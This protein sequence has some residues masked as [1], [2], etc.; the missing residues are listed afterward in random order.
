MSHFLLELPVKRRTRIRSF[1]GWSIVVWLFV[2]GLAEGQI[3]PDN[4]QGA[5]NSQVTP[6]QNINGLPADLIEGGALRDSNLFH[7]FSE[8]NVEALRGAYFANPDGVANIFSRVTG[9]NASEIMGTLGVLGDADLFLIN[10]NGIIF[11]ENASLDV[12]GS[13]MAT[14]ADTVDFGEQGFWAADEPNQ[15]PLLTV[16]PS[17]FVFNQL[18]P[19]SIENRSVAPAGLNLSGN[20]ELAG[21]RVPDGGNLLV[22]GGDIAIDGGGLNALDGRIELAAVAGTGK[23]SL[24]QNNSLSLPDAI[25]KAN[26]SLANGAIIDT[27][28]VGRGTVIFR[29]ND[30]TMEDAGVF[31]QVIVPA[32][33][34]Q[35]D[36]DG[37]ILDAD[38][39]IFLTNS[40]LDSSTFEAGNASR[41]RLNSKES[42]TLDG[43]QIAIN[44]GDR[45]TPP[46]TMLGQ[47]GNIS[48]TTKRLWIGNESQISTLAAGTGNSG[49]INLEAESLEV[50]DASL[51]L[52]NTSGMGNAGKIEVKVGSLSL[53]DGGQ[54]LSTTEEQ[55]N[56]GQIRVMADEIALSR[57]AATELNEV[58]FGIG[59]FSSG[60]FVS[61]E[62]GASG[63]GGEIEILAD[64]LAMREGAVIGA[65]TKNQALGGDIRIDAETLTVDRGAQILTSAFDTGNAGNIE[66]NVADTLAITG[67]DPRFSA[68]REA[69]IAA[70]NRI[71]VDNP[72]QLV[73][74]VS[75]AS[76]IFANTTAGSTGNSGNITI[77]GL[78][79][80][81]QNLELSQ[82]G[83]IAVDSQGTGSGGSL[84]V[85]AGDL[86]LADN[87]R[88][89]AASPS[90]QG[91]NVS[92]QVDNL[93]QM[94]NNSPITAEASGAA[95]GGNIEIDTGFLVSSGNSDI[96]ANAFMGRGGLIQITAENGVFGLAT[97]SQLTPQGD[98]TAFSQQN[99]ELDGEVTINTIKINPTQG[100]LNLPNRPVTAQVSQVCQANP[101]DNRNE[102]ILFGRGGLSDS[103]NNITNPDTGWEDWGDRPSRDS[104][105]DESNEL[106]FSR[107]SDK[108]AILLEI[109]EARNWIVNASGKIELV[110]DS[111]RPNYWV[112]LPNCP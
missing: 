106:K 91:G 54:I 96:V 83:Q 75:S 86:T 70:G 6:E 15:P 60:L 1:W 32:S 61:A 31:N 10:P 16:Q 4:T 28:G 81:I 5:E 93:L 52:N 94:S 33:E 8:F 71:G 49:N 48:L 56:A 36:R 82:G 37:L 9:N 43:S 87:A 73:D 72:E 23:V 20:T 51:I 105:L 41:V 58:N 22:L 27:S 109:M 95:D 102:F 92:L 40:I 78:A 19:G 24:N 111:S 45:D 98:I 77:S 18:N 99:P 97:R 57:V 38:R 110:A 14:T 59:G 68:R 2:G 84:S 65:R 26:I 63:R 3:T 88:I 66:L 76:G 11:G 13:F 74:P 90:G 7:S 79:E 80:P 17:A 21:L 103:P 50:T 30:I 44:S 112:N 64:S 62:Q 100:L 107:D 55:G 104:S 42:I 69:V 35:V 47:G 85:L 12:N 67:S 89:S 29:G 108:N 39:N 101:A 25:A 46:A 53:L 34:Q